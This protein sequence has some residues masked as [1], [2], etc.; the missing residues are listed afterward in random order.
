MATNPN[1]AAPSATTIQVQAAPGLRVPFE[2]APRKYITDAGAVTVTRSA[3]Y[4][5]RLK[6]QDL[7]LVT[8]STTGVSTANASGPASAPSSTA[9]PAAP[10][11]A[12]GI[13]SEA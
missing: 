13:A 11:Q 7:V 6:D 8:P 4:L 3:Y 5:R 2:G 12:R 9:A 10:V 1:P